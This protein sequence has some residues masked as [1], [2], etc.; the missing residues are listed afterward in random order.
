MTLSKV[1]TFFYGSYI[2]QDVLAEVDLYPTSVEVVRLS[3]FA[4]TIRPLANLVR[5]DRHVVYGILAEATHA[6]LERLYAHAEHI[7]GGRYLPEAVL[8]ET[9]SGIFIPALCYISHDL[10]P[11]PAS[12]AY[13]DRIARPAEAYGFPEWYVAHLKSFA[14]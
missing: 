13:V 9:E 7:L 8:C 1:R 5:S 10:V 4:I 12:A 3:G 2:N 11:N 6:E 14:P